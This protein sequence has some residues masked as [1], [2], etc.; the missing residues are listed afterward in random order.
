MEPFRIVIDKFVFDNKI[1]E[2]DSEYKLKLI[3]IFDQ[4]YNYNNKMYTL[5]DI[6]KF[7]T[8]DTLDVLENN[9]KYKGFIIYE[10]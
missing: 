8:K 5:K 10:E 3:S 9:K 1:K 7:Y 6:I 4:K 2:F